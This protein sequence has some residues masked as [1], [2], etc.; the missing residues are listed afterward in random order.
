MEKRTLR[1]LSKTLL[2]AITLCLAAYTGTAAF[3]YLS[4]GSDVNADV[5]LSYSPTTDV[6]IAVALVAVKMY[7]TYPI[8]AFVGR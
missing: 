4:F 7:S 8:L 5:L 1:E 3:G 2:V 6:L